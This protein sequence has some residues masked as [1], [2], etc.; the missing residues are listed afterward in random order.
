ML[1]LNE[2]DNWEYE[3]PTLDEL[4]SLLIITKYAF[5]REGEHFHKNILPF[6]KLRNW[7]ID[8]DHKMY[9]IPES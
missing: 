6:Y 9:K 2:A 7:L 8:G 1:Y 3:K 5:L 4:R